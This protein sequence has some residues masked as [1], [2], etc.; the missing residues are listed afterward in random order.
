MSTV[1]A[2]VVEGHEEADDDAEGTEDEK[3]DG[4]SDL[5]DRRPVVHRVRGLHHY[6]LVRYR[7]GVVHVSHFL[8]LPSS[9]THS[10]S[11]SQDCNLFDFDPTTSDDNQR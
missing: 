11:L 3:G 9:S 5:L 2:D 7:E 6:V 8:P 4:K 10:L 1:A